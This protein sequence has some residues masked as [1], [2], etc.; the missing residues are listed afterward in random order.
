VSLR[1]VVAIA[2]VAVAGL[3]YFA[4]NRSAER[5]PQATIESDGGN[6]GDGAG[7]MPTLEAPQDDPGIAWDTP[8]GWQTSG[9]Q[10]VR[11]ATYTVPAQGGGE[12]PRCAVYFFGPG[13][14]GGVDANLQRWIGEFENPGQHDLSTLQADGISISRVQVRGT[15]LAHAMDAAGSGGK[16]PDWGLLGAIAEGPSGNLF[17]KLTGPAAAVDAAARDFDAMLASIH[18]H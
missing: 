12:S 5:A 1:V 4:W 17:F 10:G 13:Q 9:P 16:R 11:L 15:Y 18:K 8:R 2:V 6:A 14:G 3:A 7:S